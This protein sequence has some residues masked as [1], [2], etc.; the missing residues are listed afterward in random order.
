MR[1][2]DTFSIKTTWYIDGGLASSLGGT[3]YIQ[4]A[5]ESI[6]PGA[7]FRSQEYPVRLDRQGRS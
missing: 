7:E 6:G 4:A 2:S 3:W 1:T 5:F